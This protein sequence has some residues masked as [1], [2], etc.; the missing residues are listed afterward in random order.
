MDM[1]EEYLRRV[2]LH[3][4]EE[5]SLSQAG[6]S[7]LLL[8]VRKDPQSFTRRE[9]DQA[10]AL[11]ADELDRY[12]QSAKKDDLLDDEEFMK[13]RTQ[14]LAHLRGV[15]SQALALDP[16]C[17]DAALC[18]AIARDLNPEDLLVELMRIEA[19]AEGDYLVPRGEGALGG[20]GDT[21]PATGAA[22]GA[23]DLWQDVFA[24]PL[25]RVK[26]AMA[27]ALLDTARYRMAIGKAQEAMHLA[28]SDV[29]G[30]R[31]TA[32]LCHARL[33]DERGFDQLDAAYQRRGD[34]W[35]GLGRVILLYKLGRI[36]A[37]KRALRGFDHLCEGGI[38]ALIRPILV[39]S[40]MPD[41]PACAPY[42]FR[43][44]TMAVHEADP[45]VVDVPDLP[46]WAES[47]PEMRQSA[48]AFAER[49]GFDWY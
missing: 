30:T 14:R 21:A 45:I 15:C 26:A 31:H 46:S 39:D 47:I 27:R 28:P 34:A 35:Q 43:E 23:A 42:S 24:H 18:D 12:Y 2:A 44:A 8:A 7:E 25:L 38:Y 32:L 19:A 6:F 10:L 48:K 1:R 36:A 33:E 20:T 11:L 17:T 37:A 41:R 29:L 49:M 40:Y 5:L 4:Q 13:V 3:Q 22:E 16:R 9:D